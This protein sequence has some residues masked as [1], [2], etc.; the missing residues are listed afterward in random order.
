MFKLVKNLYK[1]STAISSIASTASLY[2]TDALN[3]Y[4][5][6][7]RKASSAIKETVNLPL[8]EKLLSKME[9]VSDMDIPQA[10]KDSITAKLQAMLTAELTK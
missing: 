5:A 10:A 1:A 6:D 3:D 7:E 8:V 4:I 2:A 9:D